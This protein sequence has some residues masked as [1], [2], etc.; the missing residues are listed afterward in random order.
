MSCSEIS[1]T[2]VLGGIQFPLQPHEGTLAASAKLLSAKISNDPAWKSYRNRYF[3]TGPLW[4]SD[5]I[6]PN[7]LQQK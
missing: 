2:T 1:Q 5:S 7:R 3:T 6:I 4:V